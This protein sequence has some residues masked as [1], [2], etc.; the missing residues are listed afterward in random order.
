MAF[1]WLP[2]IFFAVSK[3]HRGGNCSDRLISKTASRCVAVLAAVRAGLTLGQFGACISPDFR[4]VKH[5]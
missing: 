2:F 3:L 4:V 1:F 5:L